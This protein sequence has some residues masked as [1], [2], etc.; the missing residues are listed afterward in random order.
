MG[1][2][3]KTFGK[4]MINSLYGRLGMDSQDFIDI[5]IENNQFDYFNTKFNVISRKPINNLDFLK[6]EKD[7]KILKELGIKNK[8]DK[9]NVSIAA[10]IT[11]K[12]RI[13]LYNAQ[14]EVLK[15]N[16]RIL[17]SDTDSIFASFKYDVSN[18]KF[19]EIF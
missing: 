6:I 12:A 7:V 15:K 3:Y 1:N 16:G 10:A 13:K 8:K 9:S 11:A 18:K 4:L 14:Q 5:F 2:E 17:Y 19:G